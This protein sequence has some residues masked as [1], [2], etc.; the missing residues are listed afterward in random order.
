MNSVS[1]AVHMLY[2][3]GISRTLEAAFDLNLGECVSN[4]RVSDYRESKQSYGDRHGKHL[5]GLVHCFEVAPTK[6]AAAVGCP[7]RADGGFR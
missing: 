2:V 4:Q 6:V 1:A 5:G 3:D 7:H